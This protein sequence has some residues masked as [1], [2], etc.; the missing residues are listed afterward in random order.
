MTAHPAT[1]DY[2]YRSTES[3]CAH[4]VLWPALRSSL[5][6]RCPPPRRLLDFG[7]GSGVTANMLAAFG[8]EVSGIDI[9]A[10]GI[11]QARAAFPHVSFH[12]GSVYDD[13]LPVLGTF[14]VVISLEVIEHLYA[15]RDFIRTFDTLLRPS[16]TG[17][18]STPYHGYFK[19]LAIA[20][21]GR[22]DAH[23]SP[24]PAFL[25]VGRVPPIAMSM[26]ALFEK[27][28]P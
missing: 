6:S 20:L 15:P 28:N 3:S 11:A 21:A 24:Q 10:S 5:L 9:S 23:F 26:V 1:P 17:L 19:N 18:I 16:G 7:C 2:G 13:L 25:R 8:Y 14:D 12:V 4:T 27:P 22:F